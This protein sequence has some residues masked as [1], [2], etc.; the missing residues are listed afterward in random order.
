M[1]TLYGISNCDTV[2]KA[3]RWLDQQGIAYR[4]HD[5]RRD[6]LDETRL[7]A[8]L[9]EFGWERLINRRGRSWRELPEAARAA[10]DDEHA[11]DALLANPTLIRRPLLE[12]NTS[13]LLGF[14]PDDYQTLLGP[15]VPGA[16]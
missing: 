8:W 11:V 4:F 16:D 2:R 15:P 13:R 3:R 10:M 5:Y 14:A 9:A 12:H 6:G 7:R 1:I